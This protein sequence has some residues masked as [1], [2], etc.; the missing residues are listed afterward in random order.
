MAFVTGEVIPDPRGA[1]TFQVVFKAGTETIAKWTVYSEIL[2][3]AQIIEGLKGMQSRYDEER[4]YRGGA[5]R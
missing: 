3:K 1:D 5:A 2:G 4:P